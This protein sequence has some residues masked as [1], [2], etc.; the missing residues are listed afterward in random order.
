M[1]QRYSKSIFT[2]YRVLI[3]IPTSVC[4]IFYFLIL[5]LT[6]NDILPQEECNV[7]FS[8]YSGTQYTSPSTIGKPKCLIESKWMRVMQHAVQMDSSSTKINDWLWI[9]YHD[10]I[11]VVVQKNKDEYLILKQTKYALEGR[12]S[13]A[14]IGGIIEP[15]ETAEDAAYREVKEELEYDCNTLH[16]LGRFRTDVNRGMGWVNSFVATDC[17][18]VTASQKDILD[19]SAPEGEVGISDI[20]R[21]DVITM[22]FDEV[23]DA[24][25]KGL[26][27]EVQWSNTVSLAMLQ[28]SLFN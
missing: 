17:Q 16:F 9:D 12:Q 2:S 1:P 3:I 24:C 26:F 5:H 11:N 8:K 25:V 18:K 14:I 28:P 15:G 21:Q 27:L 10:R 23:K 7:S 22:T 4:L 19:N 6:N 20:E 13:L